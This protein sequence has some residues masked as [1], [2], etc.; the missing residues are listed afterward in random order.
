MLSCQLSSTF[1]RMINKSKEQKKEN[2]L[3]I[4]KS[5]AKTYKKANKGKSRRPSYLFL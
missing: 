4:N 3:D 2:K 1:E 5:Q